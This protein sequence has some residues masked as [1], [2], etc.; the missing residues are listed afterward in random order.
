MTKYDLSIVLP[1]YNEESNIKELYQRLTELLAKLNR[2]YEIIFTDDGS[3][4]DSFKLLKEIAQTDNKIKVIKFK[5]NFGQTAALAAGIDMAQGET[6][7]TLDSDLENDP[8]DI[9]KL[10]AKIDEGYDIVSGIRKNRWQGKLFT[11]KLTSA[12][13]NWLTRKISGVNIHDLGCTLKAY[14]SEIIK[15]VKLYGEM[16]RFIAVLAYWQGGKLGEVEVNFQPRKYGKSRYGLERVLKVLLDLVT[17]KYL[18]SYT[19]K[20]IYFFGK[21]GLYSFI[22]SLI[23]FIIACYY[24]FTGQK[25][26]I[27]TPLP[28][29]TA[30]FL[31]I[32]VQFI[33][34]GLIAD[35]IMRNYFETQGKTIYLIKEKINFN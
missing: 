32:G 24:K 23:S 34:M 7:I 33:L 21:A 11:R 19:T 13:A 29:L 25:T 1:I 31:I 20:P 15:G 12:L 22:L 9:S 26:F 17:I 16:H 28:I 3:T 8:T 14:R 35:L 30:L 4:D 10:L 18:S 2:N 5:R 6:I 27:Q